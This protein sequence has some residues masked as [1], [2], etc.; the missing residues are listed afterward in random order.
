MAAPSEIVMDGNVLQLYRF[1]QMDLDK[2]KAKNYA[3]ALRD[4]VGADN[5]PPIPIS[6]PIEGVIYW[7]LRAQCFVCQYAGHKLTPQDFGAPADFGAN[8]GHQ[9]NG[10]TDYTGLDTP[11]GLDSDIPSSFHAP[12]RSPLDMR[13]PG[14]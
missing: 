4:K 2:K 11:F 14:M 5:L 8:L 6:G 7:L 13:M 3:T 12:Q 1:E 9:N 10:F